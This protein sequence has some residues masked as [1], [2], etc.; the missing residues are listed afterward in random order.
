MSPEQRA[1]VDQILDGDGTEIDQAI[2]RGINEALR[3]HKAAG[4]PIVVWRDGKVVW[5]PADEIVI[6]EDDAGGSDVRGGNETK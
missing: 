6:E 4:K 1:K 5:V 2:Q 3:K